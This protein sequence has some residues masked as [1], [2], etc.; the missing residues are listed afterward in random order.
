MSVMNEII[1][2]NE[3]VKIGFDRSRGIFFK[4]YSVDI[5]LDDIFASWEYIIQNNLIDRN[6][7]GFVLDYTKVDIK[8]SAS[9]AAAITNFYN[10]HLD[11]FKGEKIGLIMNK[12]KQLIFPML[13][14]SSNPQYYPEP[15][16]TE[17]AA[18]RWI[19]E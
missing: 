5:T 9:V 14:A 17:E 12:P 7:K 2:V 10:S 19:M 8:I 1:T 18:I 15:F 3:K 13:V 6:V 11:T 16:M 4:W